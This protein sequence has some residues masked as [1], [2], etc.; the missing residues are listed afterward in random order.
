MT[1]L[2]ALASASILPGAVLAE[3]PGA[4]P[5][6]S[7]GLAPVVDALPGPTLLGDAV[8]FHGRGYGHGVGLDQ[9]AAKSMAQLGYSARQILQYYYPGVEFAALP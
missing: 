9:A 1:L 7:T 2:L 6:P 3:S 4:S 8:T 5:H